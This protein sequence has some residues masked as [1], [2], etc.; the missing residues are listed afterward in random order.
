VEEVETVSRDIGGVTD[1][2]CFSVVVLRIDVGVRD[3]EELDYL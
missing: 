2:W 3:E 1:Q